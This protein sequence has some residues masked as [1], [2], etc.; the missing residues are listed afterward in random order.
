MTRGA[1]SSVQRS[2]A[3]RIW[4][5]DRSRE[6]R[7][8]RERGSDCNGKQDRKRSLSQRGSAFTQLNSFRGENGLAFNA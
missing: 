7:G 2:G 3:G 8:R 5:R 6:G 1:V 4:A